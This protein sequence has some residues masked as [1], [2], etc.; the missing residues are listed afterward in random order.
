MLTLIGVVNF[1]DEDGN[2]W[3]AESFVDEN[4]VTTTQEILISNSDDQ[5]DL[6]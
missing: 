1:L 3:L 4:N 6:I 5:K 2:F